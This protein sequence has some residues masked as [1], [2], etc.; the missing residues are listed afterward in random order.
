MRDRLREHERSA[1]EPEHERE[2]PVA[3]P[4]V[5]QILAL[6]RG[7]GNATV[8]RLLARQPAPAEAEAEQPYQTWSKDEI[9][10]I[11][12]QLRRLR[13][14]NLSIDGV[15]GKVSD[16]GLV[17]AFGG[18]EWRSLDS[19]TVLQRLEAAERPKSGGGHDLR[20]GELFKD[21]LLD[22]TFG[23]GFMEELGPPSGRSTP[24]TSRTR[25]PPAATPRTP[26]RRPSCTPPP[27]SRRAPSAAS[28]SSP[29]RSPTRRPPA[30]P[31]RS[32]RSSASS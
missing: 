20:Y 27:A 22:L 19:A 11:Q 18:D 30:R 9:R 14:Y 24:R 12:R 17:E 4:E 31:G 2:T 13:L 1:A 5:A 7:A 28:S 26:R 3:V 10:P 21:G 16:Q 8:A 32:R 6:Q 15:L 29:T 25:S 23:Y